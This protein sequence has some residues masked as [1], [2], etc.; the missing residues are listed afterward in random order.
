MRYVK[1][2]LTWEEGML[3][4]WVTLPCLVIGIVLLILPT[5]FLI[6]WICRIFI[7]L[8]FGPWL[9]IYYEFFVWENKVENAL[10]LHNDKSRNEY[11]ENIFQTITDQF[12]EIERVARMKGE[13]AIKMKS[14]RMLRFGQF[15]AKVP[16]MNITRNYDYPLSESKASHISLVHEEVDLNRLSSSRIV[17]S[18]RLEGQMIPMTEEQLLVYEENSRVTEFM[19]ANED[20]CDATPKERRE[21]KETVPT[22]ISQVKKPKPLPISTTFETENTE[23]DDDDVGPQKYQNP[24]LWLNKTVSQFGTFSPVSQI[25]TL[26]FSSRLKV[27]APA[28]KSTKSGDDGSE[29][30]PEKSIEIDDKVLHISTNNILPDGGDDDDTDDSHY[31]SGMD[32]EDEDLRLKTPTHSSFDEEGVEI[33][34]WDDTSE[35]SE[36]VRDDH[37]D[38]ADSVA[39]STYTAYSDAS[40]LSAVFKSTDSVYMAFCRTGSV[41]NMNTSENAD[42]KEK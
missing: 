34:A 22:S 42:L 11:A 23:E 21:E 15:I 17:P 29:E 38:D 27:A 4:F 25:S 9:R 37:F 26:S 10:Y 12:Q 36:D 5:V 40:R 28:E 19:D 30:I 2:I 18:Q 7:W 3:S 32:G 13:D 8:C 1:K 31:Q 6:H 35:M 41:S 16:S 14:M 24:R 20:N 33:V 39:S